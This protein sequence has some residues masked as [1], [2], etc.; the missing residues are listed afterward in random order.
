[1]RLTPGGQPSFFENHVNK[2]GGVSLRAPSVHTEKDAGL[3]VAR[4]TQQMASSADNLTI[5]LIQM[6]CVE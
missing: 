1:V 6:T 3:Q 5:G 2:L 4:S